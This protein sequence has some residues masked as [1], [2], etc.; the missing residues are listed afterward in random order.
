M[1]DLHREPLDP[2]RFISNYSSGKMGIA[3]ADTAADY[4]ASVELVLGPVDIRPL[5]KSVRIYNVS[6]AESM[7]EECI[8]RFYECDIAILSAAVADFTP[9]EVNPTQNKKG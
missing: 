8:P 5:N 6:T 9:V 1:P 2:V 4:G 7:A 3:L